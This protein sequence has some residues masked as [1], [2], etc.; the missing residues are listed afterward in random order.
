MGMK[1]LL[2]FLLVLVMVMNSTI[3]VMAGRSSIGSKA[4]FSYMHPSEGGQ[5]STN[6]QNFYNSFNY[7]DETYFKTYNEITGSP[8]YSHLEDKGTLGYSRIEA[9]GEKVYVEDYSSDFKYLSTK[10]IEM[11]L[12][13]FGGYYKG[14]EYRFF[15]FGQKN[16]E[17]NDEAE[18]LRI[19]KYDMEWNRLSAASV[20]GAN[21]VLPFYAGSL[22]MTEANGLLCIHTSH[23]MYKTED[24]LNHQAN[25]TFVVDEET[26]EVTQ[27]YYIIMNVSEGYVSH[28]F[29]QFVCSDGTYFYRLDHGDAAPRAIVAT[30]CILSE[31][32]VCEMHIVVPIPVGEP[33]DNT[34]GVS[35]GGFQLTN[36]LLVSVGNSV[37]FDD[38]LESMYGVRNIYMTTT[39]TGFTNTK[40]IWLTNYTEESAVKVG[41]PKLVKASED[42]FYV[43]WEEADTAN[44]TLFFRVAKVSTT[45]E[46]LDMTEP[47]Y[48]RLS[49]CEPVYTR[50]GRLVWYANFD[51]APV[52]YDIDTKDLK[53]YHFSEI[54]IEKCEIT[55]EQ[56]ECIYGDG[57]FRNNMIPIKATY[58]NYTLKEGR[59]YTLSYSETNK[60]GKVTITLEGK[61]YFT[62]KGEMTYNIRPEKVEYLEVYKAEK[63]SMK[64]GWKEV[65]F[66]TGYQVEQKQNGSW[67]LIQTVAE[68][69]CEVT[70]LE[71]Y[72]CYEFRVRA[73]T[74]VDENVY[75]G[76]YG[77]VEGYTMLETPVLKT[78]KIDLNSV[79]LEW[80][81]VKGAV[82]YE[83]YWYDY[84]GN[85]ADPIT[86][87]T[88]E[89]SY[90]LTDLQSGSDHGFYV[91][92]YEEDEEIFSRTAHVMVTLPVLLDEENT[93]IVYADRKYEYEIG[94]KTEPNVRVNY[95]ANLNYGYR[96][97]EKDISYLLAY[98]NNAGP[99][100]GKIIITGIGGYRGTLEKTFEIV[101]GKVGEPN[102]IA[103]TD[104]IELSWEPIDGATGYYVYVEKDEAWDTNETEETTTIEIEDGGTWLRIG[105]TSQTSYQVK[106]LKE[107]TAYTFKVSSFA[108]KDEK[109]YE[110]YL[111]EEKRIRT[112]RKVTPIPTV[113][114]KATVTPKQDLIPTPSVQEMTP[115]PSVQGTTPT[116]SVQGMTVT[117]PVQESTP[118]PTVQ[119]TTV[120]P[121]VEDITPIP[122]VQ[123]MTVTPPVEDITPI[124][125]VQGTTVTP[126]VQESTPIP[127]VQGTTVTPPV[128]ESTPIPTV[129]GMTVTP[130]V[131]ESTPIP[132]V[133]GMT[134]TPPVQESTPIPTVQGMTVTPPVQ[135]T[136]PIPTGQG[137]TPTPVSPSTII[138]TPTEEI[139]KI[140]EKNPSITPLVTEELS[141]KKVK[142]SATSYNYNG[143][144]KKP[145]V[146]VRNVKGKKLTVGKD[147]TVTYS[148]GRKNVG[149]YTVMVTG[150]GSYSGTV[151]KT[152]KICPKTTKITKV[153]ITDGKMKVNWKKG[154][155][156][157]TGYEIQ[158]SNSSN[159]KKTGKLLINKKKSTWKQIKNLKENKKYYV[160]IR[161]YQ[162]VKA[163]GKKVKLYSEWSKKKNVKP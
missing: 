37:H 159:F 15:V 121:S 113:T 119:G 122:T 68:A 56:E 29:N 48:G 120:T 110:G 22:R 41:V 130:P 2:S 128:Q 146:T 10:E 62:G 45:G 1:K 136:T 49:D 91:R 71:S 42:T 116:P 75:Y 112:K 98:E 69:E 67:N 4:I 95:Y 58:K 76:E 107:N 147:Y 39:D 140:P 157:I 86:L 111:S 7:I 19:V 131:Q 97:L 8:I 35:V 151:E 100:I 103:T 74:E 127:T 52:F 154:S 53:S 32:D 43:L 102:G 13:I 77:E 162:T 12:P 117:P 85:T 24:G 84:D 3:P 139:T 25:M 114:Q 78:P 158:Y 55:L 59:D 38:T 83:V 132:T 63:E 138:P 31:I 79:T 161:T 155:G 70:G 134:V 150:K 133:Q 47:I 125:T 60:V 9:I 6:L 105:T 141:S 89:L 106:G 20:C 54:D 124:P 36:D 14:E 61:G 101:P 137:T 21:T 81:A 40:K 88:T 94:N 142:L 90:T 96:T 129:Q 26:M 163:D 108:E 87:E 34:T 18:I 57:A 156:S 28:S 152:F 144:V 126:P 27:D 30:K 11:E 143:K 51:S 153:S 23:M 123:G 50:D 92:A 160:R 149:I 72:T 17:E 33:G 109:I 65:N 135:E 145:S 118:I 104:T 5:A 148:K 73:Y 80:E 64:F 93:K 16:L 46:I 66:T 99:G 115:T 44:E 82:R